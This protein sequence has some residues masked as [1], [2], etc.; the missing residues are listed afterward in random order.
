VK[1][2]AKFDYVTLDMGLRAFLLDRAERIHNLARM[3]ATGIVQVGQAL[4]EVKQRLG[5]GRFLE[6]L[7]KE[8]GWKERTA[9]NFMTVHAR[10]KSANFADLSIDVSAL[11]RIAAPSFP[12]PAR[13]QIMERAENGEVITHNG[14]RALVEHFAATGT[15]PDVKVNLK[16]LIADRRAVLNPPTIEIEKRSP[17][18]VE[19]DAEYHRQMVANGKANAQVWDVI[20]AI[21]ALNKTELLPA[22]VAKSILRWDTPDKDYRGQA[23]EANKFL[24]RVVMELKV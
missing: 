19:E 5:H 13:I 16:Q 1:N 6:W 2:V 7:G 10:F 21:E 14:V 23:S 11:Y 17:R 4:T 18:Q 12:E 3:T 22:Q 20:R 9:E 15:V 24:K 8:F